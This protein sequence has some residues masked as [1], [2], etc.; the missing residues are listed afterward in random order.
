MLFLSRRAAAAAGLCALALAGCGSASHA[1]TS[2]S[3]AAAAAV[4]A[5][6]GASSSPVAAVTPAKRRAP[7]PKRHVPRTLML[8]GD[9]LGVGISPLLQSGLAGWSVKSDDLVGRPLA[10]GMAIWRQ[11][12]T[13]RPGVAAFSLFTNDDPRAISALRSA[14]RETLR[15]Q[16]GRCV[17]WATIHRAPVGGFSYT[18]ANHLLKRMAARNPMR[19]KIVDWAGAVAANPSLIGPDGVHGT[20]AGYAVR[21]RMYENAARSCV[22]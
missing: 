10:T 8:V 1:D 20:S 6:G 19:L 3:A 9:S 5:A 7:R 2:S 13:A 18:A 16:N 11:R 4:P 12:R 22:R 17:I 15:D 14:V 21:A